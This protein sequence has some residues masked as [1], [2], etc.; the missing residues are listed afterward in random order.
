MPRT[1][2]AK[3]KPK[4]E[5]HPNRGGTREGAG[6]PTKTL[7]EEQL[8]QI[9]KICMLQ[10]SQ[11]EAATAVAMERKTL[12]RILTEEHGVT[13]EEFFEQHRQSGLTSLRSKQFQVAMSGDSQMLRHLGKHWLDQKDKIELG[14]DPDAPAVFTMKMGRDIQP[15]KETKS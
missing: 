12:A 9:I 15:K 14:F 2:G 7:S 3:D 13:W 8:G 10:G 6:P 11:A 1:K 5:K 4:T